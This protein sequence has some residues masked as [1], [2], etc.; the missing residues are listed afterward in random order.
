MSA[1]TPEVDVALSL[2]TYVRTA[3]AAATTAAV[4]AAATDA[5]T[6]PS[7]T[8]S[9]S[10]EDAAKVKVWK[11][12][13][14]EQT[15]NNG[16]FDPLS[17]STTPARRSSHAGSSIVLLTHSSEHAGQYLFNATLCLLAFAFLFS[18]S[19]FLVRLYSSIGRKQ[20]A[21]GKSS[22]KSGLTYAFTDGPNAVA[23]SQPQM[24]DRIVS[25]GDLWKGW[26]LQ[27]GRLGSTGRRPEGEDPFSCDNCTAAL[28]CGDRAHLAPPPHFNVGTSYLPFSWI[29][30]S[31]PLARMPSFL[32]TTV[33][34]RLLVIVL[35]YS[36]FCIVALFYKCDFGPQ[37]PA[38]LM[39]Y[40]PGRNFKRSGIIAV[41]QLPVVLALGVR[42]N[43]PGLVIGKSYDHLRIIHKVSGRICFAAS[44]IHSIGYAV[45][46]SQA[47]K[48]ASNSATQL[49]TTGWLS[50]VAILVITITSLPY[51]RR[52]AYGVFKASHVLGIIFLIVGLAYHDDSTRPWMIATGVLYILSMVVQVSKTRI[53]E[54]ELTALSGTTTTLITIPGITT[55]WRAGQHVR[56]R[57]FDLGLLGAECHPFTIASAPDMPG[58]MLLLVKAAGDWT[59]KVFEVAS[60][61]GR[62]VFD[63]ESADGFGKRKVRMMIEGPYGGPGN[64]LIPSFSS[65]VLVAGGSGITHSLS[66]AEDLINRSPSGVVAART[67]DLI[68]SVRFEQTARGLMPRI[69]RLVARAKSWEKQALEARAQGKPYAMP[70]ALRVHLFVTRP[71]QNQALTLLATVKNKNEFDNV[72]MSQYYDQGSYGSSVEGQREKQYYQTPSSPIESDDTRILPELSNVGTPA[73]R[74]AAAD[75][76]DKNASTT[77]LVALYRR[78][79][80]PNE[81]MS[82]I[83]AYRGRADLR[84]SVAT[85]V[86]ETRYRHGAAATEPMGMYVA[87]CGPE[88]LVNDA[89]DACQAVA[90]F[91][92]E[93]INGIEFDAEFFGL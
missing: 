5:G 11:A 6:A 45:M 34:L 10:A 21:I 67:I 58:G 14:A 30:T 38:N 68:W 74:Y 62:E 42:G 26:F 48:L 32:Y 3:T 41:T 79:T 46:W 80:K 60:N 76:M 33:E 16:E 49:G 70:T 55:G 63:A 77:T 50:F 81:P 22:S 85:I 57:I 75:W 61:G 47:G 31:A 89:R 2:L 44:A 88:Y 87:A 52:I 8:T 51:I 9:L 23:K 64:T 17:K 28:P 43:I 13:S 86:D 92:R 18:L 35:V 73:Q 72:D 29:W 24:G 15:A 27:R 84:S 91:K 78:Q 66:I 7:A 4:T 1:P 53:V 54:A 36:I 40:G 20:G 71:P 59:S 82:S 39:K 12:Q 83:W 90:G 37:P 65:V 69:N 19:R 56:I 25:G 93:Q